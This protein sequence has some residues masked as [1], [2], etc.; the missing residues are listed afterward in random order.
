M[1]QVDDL[2]EDYEPGY[3]ITEDWVVVGSTFDNLEAFHGA[4][5]GATD[6]LRSATGFSNLIDLAPDPLHS[7]VY[8]DLAGILELV[9]DGL[10]NDTRSFYRREVQPFV[11]QLGAFMVAGSVTEEESRLTVVVTLQE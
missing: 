10:D 1:G 8:A 7:I 5:S 3:L 9:Y 6:S 11:G 2:F 4:A